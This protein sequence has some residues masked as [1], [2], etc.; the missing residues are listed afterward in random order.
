MFA[1]TL[2]QTV[3]SNSQRQSSEEKCTTVPNVEHTSKRDK[4][5]R[6]YQVVVA[7]ETHSVQEDNAS[8]EIH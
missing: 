4:D 8:F 1:P 2:N 3:Y 5:S 6:H 7:I